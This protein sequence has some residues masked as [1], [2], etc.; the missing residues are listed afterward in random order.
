MCHDMNE[1]AKQFLI[2]VNPAQ[3]KSTLIKNL[4]LPKIILALIPFGKIYN[5]NIQ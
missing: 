3:V 5:V 1:D 2:P 4:N